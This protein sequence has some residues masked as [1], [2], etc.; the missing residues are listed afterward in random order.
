MRQ[1]KAFVNILIVGSDKPGWSCWPDSYNVAATGEA[2]RKLALRVH[3]DGGGT[4]DKSREVDEAYECLIT[5]EYNIQIIKPYLICILRSR[6]QDWRMDT[7]PPIA[8]AMICR[9]LVQY[10]SCLDLSAEHALRCR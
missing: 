5:H 9:L 10:Q 6:Q 4:N 3:P 7:K 2:F 1:H 8:R